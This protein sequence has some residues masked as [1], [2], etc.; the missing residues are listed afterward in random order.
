MSVKKKINA[1]FVAN[2]KSQNVKTIHN[3]KLLL[4]FNKIEDINK[5]T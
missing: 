3:A 1:S 5:E 2:I 4:F